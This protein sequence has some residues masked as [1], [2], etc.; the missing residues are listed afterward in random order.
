M[1]TA[2]L[3]GLLRLHHPERETAEPAATVAATTIKPGGDL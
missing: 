3:A 2:K 1:A